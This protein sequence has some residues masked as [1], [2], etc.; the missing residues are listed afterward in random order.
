MRLR[1]RPQAKVEF[2]ISAMIDCTFLLLIYFMVASTFHKQEA[3]ISFSLPGVAEQA[4]PL[5]MPDEQILEI[6]ADGGIVLNDM[7]LDTPTSR[8]LPQLVKTLQ[9]FREASA[10][11]KVEAMLTIN[12]ADGVAH[13]RVVDVLN[14]CAEAKLQNVT[15][16]VE[17][18]EEE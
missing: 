13:Q 11:T 18:E 8:E 12:A 17:G 15:F 1:R 7:E 2:P 14:A 3:D 10:A 16:A 4:E 9:R 5:A 6:R